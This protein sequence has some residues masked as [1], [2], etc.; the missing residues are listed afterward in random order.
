[1]RRQAAILLG[2]SVTGTL[3]FGGPNGFDPAN[4]LVPSGCLNSSPGN[5][6]VVVVNPTVE[7]CYDDIANLDTAQFTDNSLTITDVM[8]FTNGTNAWTMTFAFAPGLITGVSEASDNFANGGVTAV[9]ANDILT[10]SFAGTTGIQTSTA[11]YNFNT[12]ATP[13][14]STAMLG[15]MGG[16][17][18]AFGALLRRPN[19]FRR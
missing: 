4:S 15:A 16:A 5:A 7:F 3:T 8:R 12:T 11:V 9:L 14:P 6:T 18:L 10:L 17:V 2:T 1:V 13:E 19:R